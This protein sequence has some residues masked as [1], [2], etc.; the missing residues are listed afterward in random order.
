LAGKRCASAPAKQ[1]RAELAAECDRCDHIVCIAWQHD[2]DWNLAVIR[3]VGGV[4]CAAAVIETNFPANAR[5]QSL[6]QAHGIHSRRLGNLRELYESISH[7]AGLSWL[8]RSSLQQSSPRRSVLST[9]RLFAVQFE[10]EFPA[11][12]LRDTLVIT[13]FVLPP[14]DPTLM[15]IIR[16]LSFE[17][18]VEWPVSELVTMALGNF[19][20]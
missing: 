7:T 15:V 17:I 16:L 1:R 19:A 13:I 12:Y 2:A 4:E 14:S 5:T 3:A 8:P 18:M 11:S 6:S 10:G 9:N 20:L